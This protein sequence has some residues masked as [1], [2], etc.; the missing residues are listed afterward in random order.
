MAEAVKIQVE[1]R[2]PA[3]NKGTGTR[4]ARR[5]R[6]QGRIPAILYGHKQAPVPITLSHDS[7]WEMIKR[8]THLAEL[9]LGGT[10]EMALV[11]DVQWDHLG[12]DILHVDFARVSAD[13]AIEVEV[14]LDLRGS[15]PGVAEGG[16]LEQLVHTVS[17]TCRASA[18]PE[19]IRV[20]LSNLHLNQAVHV[21]DLTG[22]PEGV[23]I[24]ADPEQLLVHVTTRA[25]APEPVAPEAE[26]EAAAAQPEVIKPERKEKEE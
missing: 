20:D 26:A 13:E 16:I 4:V 12:K 22:L 15:A 8:S 2:D 14:R 11:R 5:L 18:I 9:S 24:N 10:T 3:K 1:P 6:A 23:T 19:A 7:V 17:V 25:A 21:R